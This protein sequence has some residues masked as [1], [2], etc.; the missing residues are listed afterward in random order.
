MASDVTIKV[1]GDVTDLLGKL[2]QAG[3]ATA[4]FVHQ[5]SGLDLSADNLA[6]TLGGFVGAGAVLSSIGEYAAIGDM[7]DR[8]GVT[9]QSMQRLGIMAEMSGSSV[10][11]IT[12]ALLKMRK[13]LETGGDPALQA[14][15]GEVGLTAQ[16]LLALSP[17]QQMSTLAQAFQTAQSKGEGFNLMQQLMGKGFTSL[18]PLLQTSAE[19]MKD[20]AEAAVIDEQTLSGIKDLDDRMTSLWRGLKIGGAN[21]ATGLGDYLG[22]GMAY[23]ASLPGQAMSGGQGMGFGDMMD[24]VINARKEESERAKESAQKQAELNAKNAEAESIARVQADNEQKRA[25]AT[26]R[27]LSASEQLAEVQGRIAKVNTDA[28]GTTDKLQ[29]AQLQG[30]LLDLLEQEHAL[31]EKINAEAGRQGEAKGTLAAELAILK[32][33][34]DG[35]TKEADAMQRKLDIEQQA[36]S[37]ASATGIDMA[38]AR[39]L[40]TAQV[41]LADK[42]AKDNAGGKGGKSGD[43]RIHGFTQSQRGPEHDNSFRNLDAMKGNRGKALKDEFKFPGLDA[44][45]EQANGAA[46]AAAGVAQNGNALL[47]QMI[48]ELRVLNA[49][50]NLAQ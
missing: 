43:G 31:R 48:A 47:S 26:F 7:A 30:Q 41:D 36:K 5:V 24:E 17:E 4:G 23:L 28:A 12:K 13:T 49:K 6:G 19:D 29:Q 27:S 45:K 35:H 10:E 39:T 34:A 16:Q 33:R 2:K 44:M 9:G 1:G 22:T 37:I 14:A 3:G 38:D 15:L 50:F 11:E 40:A 21:L 20:F 18:I 42:V 46:A 25:A 32:E 8:L